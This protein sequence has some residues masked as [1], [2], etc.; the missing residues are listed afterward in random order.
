MST[1][2][3]DAETVVAEVR[4]GE[5]GSRVVAVEPGGAEMIPLSE[6]HGNPAHLVWTWMSP[7]LEFATIFVGVISILFFH[8]TFWQAVA[9]I[10]V[11]TGLGSF[12]HGVLSARGPEFGVPQ[13]ILS[14]VAFGRWGNLLPAGLN[15]VVAGIG[16]F[17]VNSVSGALALASL[18]DL[19]N[20]LCLLI[21]VAAQIVIAFFGHN[22]IQTFERY[23]LPLL[24]VIFVIASIVILSK[25]DP[26]SASA[27]KGGIGGFLLTVGAAFGYAA[28]WNPYA[29]DY[30]RYLKPGTG[31]TAGTYAGLGVFI[32][33]V[34]LEVVG[35]ASVTIAGKVTDNP[36]ADFTG[37][38]PSLVA[39]LTLLAIAVGA[40][41]ANVIN[42]YS[43]TMSF[44][45]LG[46]RLPLTLRRAIVALV[47]GIVGTAVAWSGLKDAGLK[48]ENFLLVISY[49]IGPWIAVYFTDWYLR[50][51]HRVDGFLFD[52]RH[53]PIA[54]FAAMA[55]GMVL[56]IW[57]FSNQSKYLGVVPNA[58]PKFGDLT[59][60]V[61]F[62]IS[63]V[64][65]FVLFKLQ[66][67]QQDEIL[68]LPDA[69]R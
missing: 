37:H 13:M 23:A 53:N 46:F 14:R 57:L 34:V 25:A 29:T 39:N 12:A 19:S 33:C 50:R 45:A 40:V 65:Y 58:H 61:G 43:G 48:Y 68:V 26:S 20:K 10:V 55:I 69:A 35:A 56:S 22:L 59:F 36:T 42:I 41:S 47:F 27:N 5:Y 6:R 64:V 31:R 1:L 7:N 63:A 18:T 15:A 16:W 32:S 62:V 60:E 11:G 3:P 44:L 38:L 52:K 21:V 54:G 24:A 9:A 28:G 30:T 67:S 8:Q 4:E 2:K 51:G 49:W 17:A 66:P